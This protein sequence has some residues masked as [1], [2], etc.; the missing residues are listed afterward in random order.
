ME[1][2]TLDG[3]E[4][5]DI[6]FTNDSDSTFLSYVR[7]THD[8]LT[9]MIEVKNVSDLAVTA[10]NQCATYLG[11]RIGRFGLLVT[12][13][14][15]T[16]NLLRKQISVFNDSH[17]RKVLLIFSDTDLADLIDTRLTNRSPIAW[18]QKRYRDFRTRVQ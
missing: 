5:R 1:V 13:H 14:P 18:L 11:D 2:R 12:R 8:A 6:I 16:E 15:P 4:R 3:T 9:I 7:I 10:V 17:P